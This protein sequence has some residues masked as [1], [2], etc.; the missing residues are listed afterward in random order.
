M[1]KDLNAVWGNGSIQSNQSEQWD[2]GNTIGMAFI[3][4]LD[5]DDCSSTCLIEPGYKWTIDPSE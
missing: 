3:L 5:G 2:D 4:L 1:N